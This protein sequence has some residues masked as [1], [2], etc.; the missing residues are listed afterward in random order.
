MI[1][2]SEG[3]DMVTFKGTP[4][5]KKMTRERLAC[6]L[7]LGGQGVFPQPLLQSKQPRALSGDTCHLDLQFVTGEP[8][9]LPTHLVTLQL[10]T[11][12]VSPV[13]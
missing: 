10:E 9:N 4:V 11:R 7:F 13:P 2:L 1:W 12:E 5:L 3:G 6:L 8:L